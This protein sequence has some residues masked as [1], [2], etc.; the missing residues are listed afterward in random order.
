MKANK[1]LKRLSKIQI[2]VSDVAER[3]PAGDGQIGKLLEQ[4]KEAVTRAVAAVKE[5]QAA[6]V[7]GGGDKKHPVKRSGSA[8]GARPDSAS[9]QSRP[10]TARRKAAAGSSTAKT[11]KVNEPAQ[12]LAMKAPSGTRKEAAST[13][14]AYW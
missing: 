12:K 3:Y 2:L 9:A 4:A 8:A 11:A 10:A 14:S 7:S 13:Q 5:Q 6:E 1:A